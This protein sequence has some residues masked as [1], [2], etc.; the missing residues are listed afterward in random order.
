[1]TEIDIPKVPDH[2]DKHVRNTR[3]VL[4]MR[5]AGYQFDEI[6]EILGYE[7]EI[8]V[9][10]ELERGAKQLIKEDAH[11]AKLLRG[12]VGRRL[13]RMTRAVYTKAIDPDHPE[14]MVAQQRTL[15][16]V[17]RFIKLYGLDAPVAHKVE[18]TPTEQ[19]ITDMINKLA[20]TGNLPEEMN[21]FEAEVIEDVE[22]VG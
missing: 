2:P 1:M 10:K 8:E 6:A 22:D 12:I 18:V 13:E 16:N 20:E 4:H 5:I 7:N 14:Q 15:A 17:D 3:T 11:S 19:A 21:I 9:R